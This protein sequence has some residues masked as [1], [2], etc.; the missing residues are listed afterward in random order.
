MTRVSWS[1]RK[2]TSPSLPLSDGTIYE[3]PGKI[4]FLDNTIDT[5]TG[6]IAVFAEFPDP[7]LQLVPG[8]FVTVT[9]QSGEPTQLPIVPAAA[10]QQDRDGAFVFVL[11]EGSHAVV[12]RVSLGPRVGVDWSVT[13]GLAQRRNHYHKRNPESTGGL[14][15]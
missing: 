5:T 8:Q 1:S 4:A 3:S 11:D 2:T 13:S 10:V 9:V 14:S 12:R 6:T 7:R 15:S